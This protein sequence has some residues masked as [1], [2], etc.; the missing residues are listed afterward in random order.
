MRRLGRYLKERPRLLQEFRWQHNED[1]ELRTCTDRVWAGD[2]VTRKST[3]G[4]IAFSGSHCIK[5]WSSNQT[6]IALS[7]AELELYALLKGAGQSLG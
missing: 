4:G 5:S 2:K 3:S 6:I 1:R 7:S